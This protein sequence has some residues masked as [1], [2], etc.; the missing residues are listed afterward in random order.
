MRKVFG[1]THGLRSQHRK[2]L[3]RFYRRKINPFQ[4]IT[5]EVARDLSRLSSNIKRQIGLLINRSG[6]IEQVIVGDHHSI[7]I[8]ELPKSRGAKARLR[9]LR[10]IHTHLASEPITQDDLM[11]LVFLRF[12]LLGVVQV[13]SQGGPRGIEIAHLLPDNRNGQGWEILP[14]ASIHDHS[15][16]F[17]EW[18]R[19]LENEFVRKQNLV[20]IS[21]GQERVILI[22]VSNKPRAVVEESMAELAELAESNNLVVAD[23][24][25]QRSR[26]VNPKYLMGKGKLREIIIKAMQLGV[27]LLIFDQELNPSQVRSITDITEL[28]VIDRTQLI[29]DI[30]AQRARSREGKIQV[31]MAQL[32]Y[33][34]PRLV[35]K[36]DALS[37]LTG[38]IGGRGPGE[39]KLEV[40]R[41]RVRDRI[42]RLE[43]EL[44]QVKKQRAQQK[45]KRRRQQLPIISI[46]GYTNA[47]KSTLLNSLT[48]SKVHVEDRLFATLDP[49]SKRLRFPRDFEVIITDTVGFIKDL[50]R[51]LVEAFAATLEELED[52]NLLLHVIDLS[53]P[54]FPEHVKS[55]E[56]ILGDLGLSS[57]PTIRVL[58]KADL[59]DGDYAKRQ[60]EIYG[61]IAI[62][63]I[64]P[65]SLM[66]LIEVMQDIIAPYV[67][68]SAGMTDRMFF[69]KEQANRM[70]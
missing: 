48:K 15:M 66:P 22:S 62:S 1:N 39:T 7:L 43:R 64:D 45:S 20:P 63:A 70:N 31:E 50:P 33:M 40:D 3:E 11:D 67:L 49:T 47:G 58:N 68:G 52:A 57:I 37:R 26:R 2:A 5:P 35:K 65:S 42:A 16:N 30:F 17:L 23:T 41:R 61:G 14:L 13:D 38:G 25:I 34:L 56:R 60:C 53:N 44:A 55:V 19:A 36:D 12:D 21:K 32:K 10:Y 29:L 69:V 27:D 28:R 9:G 18:V 4:V 59:V 51:D 6:N 46:V 54:G 8:P 24:I